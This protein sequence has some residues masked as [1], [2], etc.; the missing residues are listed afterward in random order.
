MS[1]IRDPS[2]SKQETEDSGLFSSPSDIPDS[3][4]LS[5]VTYNHKPISRHPL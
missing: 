4:S 1:E 2:S 3:P 5:P